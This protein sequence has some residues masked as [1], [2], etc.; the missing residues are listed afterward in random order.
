[1]KKRISLIAALGWCLS[2]MAQDTLHL[3]QA[4]ELLLKNNYDIQIAA[5]EHLITQKANTIGNAG[6][7]PSVDA[8]LGQ[9][10]NINDTRQ[11]YFSGDIRQGSGVK[12]STLNAGVQLSWT[13]FDGMNMF[14]SKQ[15]LNELELM[16]ELN[17]R[18]TIEE[19]VYHLYELYYSIALQQKSIEILKSAIEISAERRDIARQRLQIGAAST[20]DLLQASVDVN[21]D[22]SALLQH[23][24]VLSDTRIALNELLALSPETV[25]TVSE[26]ITA[27]QEF[28][29]NDL[30]EK[31][32]SQNTE[33]S[34]V[35]SRQAIARM[36]HRQSRTE[37]YPT[38]SLSSGYNLQRSQAELGLIKNGQN[39][40]LYY[41]FTAG[42]SLFDGFRV[43]QRIRIEAVRAEIAGLEREK[44]EMR[45][46][47][48]LYRMFTA[49]NTRRTIIAKEQEN[50]ETARKT[51]EVALEKMRLGS[52]SSFELREAQR[53][54]LEAEFRLLT[55]EYEA[56]IAEMQLQKM[57]G[58]ILP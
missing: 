55:A 50:V 57:C 7:L 8:S 15:K 52:L 6:F 58:M 46:R 44:A 3:K 33:L 34:I 17:A 9:Q 43:Q 53:R 23:Q 47:N 29:F 4:V 2:A 48:E 26:N 51:H 32:I 39:Q 37:M 49:W 36:N 54:L 16:G 35:R 22:S 1:M 18:L 24:L 38:L 10:S 30:I 19:S 45:L 41:G 11:E 28:Q 56:G 31:M 13:I 21:A 25:F 12:S 27:R 42:I 5:K 40:G 14:I 20:L